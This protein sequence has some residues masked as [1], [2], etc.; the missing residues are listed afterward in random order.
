MAVYRK[1]KPL[2][3]RA[4]N[5]GIELKGVDSVF[6]SNVLFQ[7]EFGNILKRK[8]INY[9]QISRN[10]FPEKDNAY[11]YKYL[12]LESAL[13]SLRNGSIRFVEPTRWEDKFEGRFYNARYTN[14]SNTSQ[15]YPFLYASC[16]SMK[17]HNEAA[18][19]VY[20]YGKM[21][22][23]AHCVQIKIN[24]NLFRKELINS[25]TIGTNTTIF[26]GLVTYATEPQICGIHKKTYR[27]KK[28]K[29]VPNPNYKKFFS[30]F[31]LTSYLNLL[32]LKRD[33]FRH[34]NEIRFFIVPEVPPQPKGKRTR[35]NGIDVFGLPIDIH[36]DWA[37]VIEEIRIDSKC[38][39]L[40]YNIFK[41][42]CLKQLKSSNRYT[43]CK[44]RAQ[45]TKLEKKFTPIKTDVYGQRRSV[46]IE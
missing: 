6:F 45:K 40:E 5:I 29:S 27:N 30:N 10:F 34:E 41:D 13:L 23:G 38:T 1:L 44:T 28:G 24:R 9:L 11:F 17:P 35:Q 19:K 37:N 3:K 26:E 39:E 20:S 8:K 46:T 36:I 25:N 21:G 31:D 42:E 2:K 7:S 22:I 18:W 33:Y 4:S 14:V 32:L 15:D 43:S 16:M 12:D